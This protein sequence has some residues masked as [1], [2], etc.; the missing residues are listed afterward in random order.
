MQNPTEL[1]DP[2]KA[3][4]V[5]PSPKT[6]PSSFEAGELNFTNRL[7][8]LMPK[9]YHEDIGNF[10]FGMR[11]GG[12]SRHGK[13]NWQARHILSHTWLPC[14]PTQARKLVARCGLM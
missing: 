6:P 3:L 2:A 5:H 7:H 9:R 8:I 12:Y 1:T 10:V 4:P 14:Q 13:I 11:Y